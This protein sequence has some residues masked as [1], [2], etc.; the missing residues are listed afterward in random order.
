MSPGRGVAASTAEPTR[1][2][3]AANQPNGRLSKTD[4][5]AHDP[6]APPTS[7]RPRRAPGVRPHPH[8]LLQ[9]QPV[10]TG[11]F[12]ERAGD[13]AAPK[14]SGGLSL[15]PLSSRRIQVSV[16][17]RA[18][19]THLRFTYKGFVLYR[20]CTCTSVRTDV[21]L[22]QVSDPSSVRC[23]WGASSSDTRIAISLPRRARGQ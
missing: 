4:T 19:K 3:T 21:R 18:R 5:D 6:L 8:D 11:M 12:D 1:A 20:A 17:G 15:G 9:E 23:L 7:P 16:C 2:H 14:L 10:A 13:N 22:L